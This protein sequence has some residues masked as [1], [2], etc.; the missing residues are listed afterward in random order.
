[1]EINPRMFEVQ[2]SDE[3]FLADY[4]I[5]YVRKTL[6]LLHFLDC[7]FALK[8][9]KIRKPIRLTCL[10]IHVFLTLVKSPYVAALLILGAAELLVIE[11][12]LLQAELYVTEDTGGDGGG[13]AEHH[14]A[15]VHPGLHAPTIFSW[16]YVFTWNLNIF[17]CFSP[18]K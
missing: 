5:D 11:A 1:M 8:E 13:A 6:Y 4:L 3:I 15:S 12:M 9:S 10:T 17:V 2:G 14:G 18:M 16:K 7:T